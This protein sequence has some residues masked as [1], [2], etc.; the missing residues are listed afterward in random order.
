MQG[1]LDLQATNRRLQQTLAQV[2]ALALQL[3]R[4][5]EAFTLT[6]EHLQ[7]SSANVEFELRQALRGLRDTLQSAQRLFDYLEQDPSALL[8]GKRAPGRLYDGQRR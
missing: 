8:V 5:S 4:S 1:A 6:L 3:Q 2:S 7:G